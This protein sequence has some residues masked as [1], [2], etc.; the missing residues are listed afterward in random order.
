MQSFS[1]SFVGVY[2]VLK[3]P[4][5]LVFLCFTAFLWSSFSK[6]FEGVHEVP[7]PPPTFVPMCSM[8]N[9]VCKMLLFVF[10]LLKN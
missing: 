9:D 10:F 6:S 1:N 3:N 7:T 2:G 8:E 5:G 4:G